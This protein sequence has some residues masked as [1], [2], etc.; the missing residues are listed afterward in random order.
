MT[1]KKGQGAY[2]ANQ[3][4]ARQK[5]ILIKWVESHKAGTLESRANQA[6]ADLGFVVTVSSMATWHH[7]IFGRIN[8]P[9]QPKLKLELESKPAVKPEAKP[10]IDVAAL[11]KAIT[12]QVMATIG[13]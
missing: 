4:N 2:S 10:E 7:A 3:L 9:P 6:T 12:E 1:A 8:T 5:Y 13:K 11:V